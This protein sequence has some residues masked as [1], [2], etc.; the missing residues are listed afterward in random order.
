[1]SKQDYY[2]RIAEKPLKLPDGREVRYSPGTFSCWESAYRKGGFD[3]LIPK[4]RSD[5]GHC[6]RLDADSISKIYELRER[7]PRLS[8]SGIRSITMA[9]SMHPM[10]PSPPFSASSAKTI[11][12]ASLLPAFGTGGLLKRNSLPACTRLI[13]FMVPI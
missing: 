2:A 1:M 8:A 5:K 7:F 9:S 3:A 4:E 6:R 13:P 10:R 11:S 12:R